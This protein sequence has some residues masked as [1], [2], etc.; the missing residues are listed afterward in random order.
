MK[1]TTEATAATQA[2]SRA[3]PTDLNW[4]ESDDSL[5]PVRQGLVDSPQSEVEG[6][7]RFFGRWERGPSEGAGCI[8]D[9]RLIEISEEKD[10]RKWPNH[11]RNCNRCGN[12]ISLLQQADMKIPIDQ[13]LSKTSQEVRES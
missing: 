12:V 4:H 7:R 2:K 11:I 8:S 3:L 13:F 10:N 9:A 5:N 1:D 6:I